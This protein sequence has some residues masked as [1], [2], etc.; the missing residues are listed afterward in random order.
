MSLKLNTEFHQ[1]TGDTQKCSRSK[2]KVQGQLVKNQDH[3]VKNVSTVKKA[4]KRQLIG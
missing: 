2:L 4:I 1:I 3:K